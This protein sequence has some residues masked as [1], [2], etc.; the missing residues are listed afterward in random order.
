MSNETADKYGREYYIKIEDKK[1][2]DKSKIKFTF[3]D[4]GK[5]YENEGI[6]HDLSE[7]GHGGYLIML[8]SLGICPVRIIEWRYSSL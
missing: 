1:P 5:I 8:E 2:T 4:R 7:Y 3:H 6:F